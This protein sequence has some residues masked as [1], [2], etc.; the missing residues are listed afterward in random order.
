MNFLLR[1][2]RD[3][4]VVICVLFLI[5]AFAS[6]AISAPIEPGQVQVVDGDTIRVGSDTYRLV[7]FNTPEPGLQARCEAERTLAARAAF[8]LRQLVAAGG[9]DLERAACACRPGTEGTLACNYGRFCG[10]LTAV[11]RDVGAILIAEGLAHKYIC[12]KTSCPRRQS[13]C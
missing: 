12:G 8:R 9:L 5:S 13:W 6:E 1:E 3:M 10:R 2:A 4:G 11:G 7:G